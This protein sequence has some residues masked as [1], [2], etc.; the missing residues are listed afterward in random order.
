M[1]SE[2]KISSDNVNN[3]LFHLLYFIFIQIKLVLMFFL[4]ELFHLMYRLF[5]SCTIYF[6]CV[7]FKLLIIENAR[8]FFLLFFYI[9]F[10]YNCILQPK[11]GYDARKKY[12][13]H[14]QSIRQRSLVT[15]TVS[16][17]VNQF[18]DRRE[19]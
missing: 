9:N 17:T 19:C 15:E 10:I 7:L 18:C 12:R 3:I 6:K 8:G 1:L 4:S 2:C 11:S 13:A 14:N 16:L 5:R